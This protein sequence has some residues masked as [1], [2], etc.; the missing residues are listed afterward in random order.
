VFWF[1]R[2]IETSASLILANMSFESL[3]SVDFEKRRGT[4]MR[5]SVQ[6]PLTYCRNE[7]KLKAENT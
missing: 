3:A 1:H 7:R 2:R 4:K 6:T 5:L